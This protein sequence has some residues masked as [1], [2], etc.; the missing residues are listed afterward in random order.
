MAFLSEHE[1]SRFIYFYLILVF[2]TPSRLKLNPYHIIYYTTLV[3]NIRM[4]FLRRYDTKE[5]M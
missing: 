5:I 3:R 1:M 2:R 4:N